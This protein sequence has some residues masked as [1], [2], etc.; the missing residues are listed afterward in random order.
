MT[1][2]DIAKC[3]HEANRAYCE[4]LGDASQRPWE[5]APEWQRVSAID[6]VRFLLANPNA[7]DSASHDNWLAHKRA[8]GWRYGPEKDAKKKTHP[9]FLQYD[10]LPKEQRAKDALFGAVVRALAPLLS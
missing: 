5:S 3:C 8:D 6:G 9:C 1:V 2:E 4:T 7:P 10:L